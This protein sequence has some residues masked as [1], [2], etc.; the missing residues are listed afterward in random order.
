MDHVLHQKLHW[1]AFVGI[2]DAALVQGL[3]AFARE[4][5]VKVE[6]DLRRREGGKG[7]TEG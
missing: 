1:L 6:E 2:D 3:E 5:T 4:G 7:G